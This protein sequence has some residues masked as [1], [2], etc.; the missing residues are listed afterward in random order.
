MLDQATL[1]RIRRILLHPRLSFA[2]MTAADLLG[3][4]LKELR[5]EIEDG[6]IV[7]VSTGLAQR[8]GTTVDEVLTRGLEDMACAHS[9]EL[10]A[11]VPGFETA[12]GW[13]A[14]AVVAST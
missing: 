11:V 2:L 14:S 6:S 5:P 13:P 1:S 7:A 4:T 12:L 9:E 8:D 3:M 10:A